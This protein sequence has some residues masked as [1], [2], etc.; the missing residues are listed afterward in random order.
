MKTLL[1]LLLPVFSFAQNQLP[2]TLF[3]VDGRSTTCLITSIDDSKIYFNYSNNAKEFVVMQAL[4]RVFLES[5][6]NI[7]EVGK[8]FTTKENILNDFIDKR[9]VKIKEQQEVNEELKRLSLTPVKEVEIEKNIKPEKFE[10]TPLFKIKDYK[11]W[12]F[13]ILYVPYNSGKVY[14]VSRNSSYQTDPSVYY[15]IE[16]ELNMEAQ[17]TYGITQD[18]RI[19]L[20]AGYKSNSNEFRYEYHYSNPNYESN[21]GSISTV[22]LKMLDFN[23]GLKYYFKNILTEKV[24]IFALLGFGKQ[25]AFAQNKY[26]QLFLNPQ[27]N[28]INEDNIE[29]FTKELNSP[30]HFN[31]GFGAEYF[32]NES[33]SL[34]SNIRV[35]YSS[36]TGKYNAR[37][38]AENETT[39]RMQELTN[40]DFVTRI[41]LGLNFYF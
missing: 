39:T 30:W 2:D 28:T 41:G 18:L 40:R 26:E 21:Q 17:L 23:L 5:F 13:G 4:E 6:G 24:N 1:L 29:E 35:L 22:G 7:Y 12:S 34:T 36:A 10:F 15:S 8:G 9:I 25:I 14:N 11:K 31:I 32:F 19:I 38:I 3:L 16:S 20:D 27:P 33:L 37:Y